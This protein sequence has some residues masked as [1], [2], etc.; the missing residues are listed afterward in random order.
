MA[1][2]VNEFR[3][4][5]AQLG[6]DDAIKLQSD[7]KSLATT[8][9][10]RFTLAVKDLFTGR[11]TLQ[12]R[13]EQAITEFKTALRREFGK[14]LG[15]IATN[16]LQ[17]VLRGGPLTRRAVETTLAMI[18]GRGGQHQTRNEVLI[19][20][21]SQKLVLGPRHTA[22][23]IEAAD[24]HGTL[25]GIVNQVAPRVLEAAE[26]SGLSARALAG[27]RAD[28]DTTG[29]MGIDF[30][31]VPHV[32]QAVEQA[33]RDASIDGAR[34]AEVGE[35]CFR[36]L[37]PTQARQIATQAAEQA[38]TTQVNLKLHSEYR[39]DH[40]FAARLD[41]KLRAAGLQG[42]ANQL[43]LHA[44]SELV[45]FAVQDADHVLSRDELAELTD[46]VI[47]RQISRI[48]EKL[49]QIAALNLP[50]GPERNTLIAESL[51][52]RSAMGPEYFRALTD[53]ARD[54]ADGLTRFGNAATREEGDAILVDTAGKLM[55][56]IRAAGL[57]GADDMARFGTQAMAL[58][59]GR[60]RQEGSNLLRATVNDVGR[61]AIFDQ[62]EALLDF[63]GDETVLDRTS[64]LMALLRC[65]SSANEQAKA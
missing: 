15:D 19:R 29:G 62:V 27:L 20:S 11:A 7:G 36:A 63:G 26:R 5:A 21:L 13:Q 55:T 24:R 44:M 34:S 61:Q 28:C 45:T 47:D 2:S 64:S 6:R 37:D 22:D 57:E 9:W 16:Y 32:S 18:E 46:R 48:R 30:R 65:L 58:M 53:A 42:H 35:K 31:A 4:S 14:E 41:E 54:V 50:Y 23:R 1:I 56:A 51:G 33:L 38:L 60:E 12:A 59:L 40:P 39:A 17:G 43:D 25:S 3:S 8:P 52:T 49:E 10:Q